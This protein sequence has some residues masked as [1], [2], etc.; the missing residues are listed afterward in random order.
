M[1]RKIDHVGIVVK[2]IDETVKIL[3]NMFG[4]KVTETITA[5]DGEFKTAL[6]SSG[7]ANLELIEPISSK[8]SM[9]KFLEQRGGGIHHLS[10]NV[11]DIEKELNALEEKGIRLVNNKPSLVESSL[12]AFVHPSSTGG[13]L[14]ELIQ[15]V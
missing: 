4:F 3:S 5:P 8:G 9:S 14:M 11:D 10:F 2:N 13:V 1:I 12:V 6:V 7:S 15:K